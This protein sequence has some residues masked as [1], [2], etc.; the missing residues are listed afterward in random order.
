MSE[1]CCSDMKRD[2]EYECEKHDNIFDCYDHLICYN[3]VFDEYGIIIHDGGSSYV[4][5]NYCPFCGKKLPHSKRDSFF[6]ILEELGYTDKEVANRKIPSEFKT[7]E[8]WK[9]RG[10]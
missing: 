2:I 1:F 9:K 5:I 4:L 3:D 6:D 10:L 7:D 8:W